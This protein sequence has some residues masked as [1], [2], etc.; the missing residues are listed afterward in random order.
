MGLDKAIEILEQIG[1]ELGVPEI[2]Q[3]AIDDLPFYVGNNDAVA[4]G[5]EIFLEL[6]EIYEATE[7]AFENGIHP[8]GFVL[9]L[10]DKLRIQDAEDV[11]QIALYSAWC[12]FQSFR[13]Q[14]TSSWKAWLLMIAQ[15]KLDKF[16]ENLYK[17]MGKV[18]YFAD[19]FEG[20]G[21]KIVLWRDY[22]K[23]DR[24][25]SVRKV[26]EKWICGGD[27]RRAV[28]AARILDMLNN[29][30][31]YIGLS[32]SYM[33]GEVGVSRQTLSK[34]TRQFIKEVHV[35]SKS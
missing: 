32:G 21:R 12:S 24:H 33:E 19:G 20:R 22:E 9:F 28:F 10:K 4:V 30:G 3:E 1:D 18:E 34:W 14:R 31:E 11:S 25:V 13:P 27:R 35:E 2:A 8:Q 7:K 5:W 15:R 26:A 23:D 6:L 17:E 29:E 16:L